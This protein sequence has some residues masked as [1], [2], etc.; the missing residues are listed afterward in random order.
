VSLSAKIKIRL[1]GRPAEGG[2]GVRGQ[3]SAPSALPISL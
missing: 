1:N 3:G 2:G